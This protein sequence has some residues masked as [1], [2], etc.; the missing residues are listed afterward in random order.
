MDQDS[1]PVS[2]GATGSES[3]PLKV[4]FWLPLGKLPRLWQSWECTEADPMILGSIFKR[5][6]QESP[7]SVMAQATIQ[8]ALNR[9]ALDKVFEVKANRQYTLE[10]LFSTVVD[11]MCLVVCRIRR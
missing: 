1:N 8:F 11:L 4:F 7:I 2:L 10:L 3:S 9:E 6:V 5:F